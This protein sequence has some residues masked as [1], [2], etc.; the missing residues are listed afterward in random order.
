VPTEEK[1]QTISELTKLIEASTISI[2]TDFS[3][4]GVPFLTDLRRR[5]REQG[6]TYR[7]VKNRLALLA[8]QQA[9]Q[10]EF[11]QL[12]EGSTGIVFG[13]GDS[14][15]IV[16]ALTEFV[17][18]SRS[19]FIIRNGLLD[20]AILSAQQLA[21]L[22]SLPPKNELIAKLLGQLQV[23]PVSLLRVLNGPLRGLMTVL[24]RRTEQLT[25]QSA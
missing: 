22:A 11:P 14:Q 16:K 9:G 5:L 15:S 21:L 7:V 1:R 6:A 13:Q 20:G 12:L 4:L 18:T 3:G 8:A 17:Q 2:A 19:G 25:Q 10:S 24:T 23:P